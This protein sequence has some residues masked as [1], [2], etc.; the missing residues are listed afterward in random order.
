MLP[1]PPQ[2]GQLASAT[3]ESEDH[4]KD[5]D[6]NPANIRARWQAGYQNTRDVLAR[7][8]WM[9]AADPLEGF[10]LHEAAEGRMMAVA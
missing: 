7:K 8:P 2:G 1:S 5:V 9:E 3:L 10:V 4:T 6:F